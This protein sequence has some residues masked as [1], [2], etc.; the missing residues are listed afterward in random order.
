MAVAAAPSTTAE[1]A[2]LH[3]RLTRFVFANFHRKLT[4]E[5][6]RDA[7]SEALTAADRALASGRPIAD[8]NAWLCT[9]AWRDAIS[10]VRRIEGE[11]RRKRLRPIDVDEQAERLRDERDLEGEVLATAGRRGDHA[12]LE[13]AWGELKPDERRA[14][15]LR[16]FDELPVD[17]VLQIL[18]CSRHHYENLTKRGLRR[19]REAL[20]EDV[21]D[22]A[23]R[24]CREAVLE[25]RVGELAAAEVAR[26]DAHL[27]SC[28]PCRAFE[29]RQRGLIALLPLPAAGV[30]DGVLARLHGV[31]GNGAAQHGEAAAE[32]AAVAAAGSAGA[33]AAGVTGAAGGL[34]A[35][36]GAAK[37]LAV[38]CSA[39]AIAAGVCAT[40][41]APEEPGSPQR[42]AEVADKS[43]PDHLGSAR[44]PVPVTAR[45]AAPTASAPPTETAARR[46]RPGS[47]GAA[48]YRGEAAARAASSPFLPESAT[49][50]Q[51]RRAPAAPD[52]TVF[53]GSDASSPPGSTGTLAGSQRG[54]SSHASSKT[55]FSEEFTP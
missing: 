49:A 55:A 50:P 10:M 33:G 54:A 53:R 5:D 16:Y 46:T 17:D 25:S 26:R 31:L 43:L 44:R 20:V 35:V 48:R 34:L 28:L 14:L 22:D 4:F 11:G 42:P 8:L 29:R 1:V 21:A 47:A 51:A 19:L 18:G 39:G 12:A 36:G 23:C 37:T 2:A 45:A 27:G 52:T 24:A 40:V 32:S 15:Y 13:R 38:V 9:A 30:V 6:A 41:T 3:D 7:A